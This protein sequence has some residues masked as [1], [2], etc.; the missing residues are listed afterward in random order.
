MPRPDRD[1]A[2]DHVVV[3][4][5]ENR[6][7]DNLLGRL[8]RPGEVPAFDGVLGRDL[9]NPV[10][11]WAR[12]PGGPALI[13]YGVPVGMNV[14]A[15][16]PGEEYQ[17]VNTQLFGGID[18]PGNRGGK[19]ARMAAPYNAP[20]DPGRPPSM[21]GFVAD[22]ISAVTAETGHQPGPEKYA[23]IMTGYAPEQMPVLSALARGFATFD[24]WFC[25]VPSQTFPNRSF[26]HAA[27]SSGYVVNVS[28]P[29][30]FPLHNTAETIF[31][32]LEAAG[33]SWRVY[34]DPARH[35]S[36]TGLIHAPRLFGRFAMKASWCWYF[37]TGTSPGTGS[38]FMRFWP[39][40]RCSVD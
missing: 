16:D 30:S 2:M 19:A 6:S 40:G 35:V 29:D 23:Q 36:G 24:R 27:S 10:P 37:L 1:H 33:L 31:E 9:S 7:F 28:P 20:A 12:T 39:W 38:R 4:M 25:D 14:P 17:H 22:Y 18:P 5:F 8:Y 26:F 32:R 34:C 11:S 3:V 15:P 13:R 21:D